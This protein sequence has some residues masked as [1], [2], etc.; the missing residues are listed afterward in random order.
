MIDFLKLPKCFTC[1]RPF[2]KITSIWYGNSCSCNHCAVSE[3]QILI[4]ENKY[5]FFFHPDQNEFIKKSAS[6]YAVNKSRFD[7]KHLDSAIVS[8]LDITYELIYT[9]VEEYKTSIRTNYDKLLLFL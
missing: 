8:A 4:I 9:L 2:D 7:I 3:H 6:Y 5:H 1:S